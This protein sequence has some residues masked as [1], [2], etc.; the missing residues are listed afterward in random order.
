MTIRGHVDSM[1]GSYVTGWAT[2]HPATTPC[3]ITITDTLGNVLAKGHATTQRH[4]LASLDFGRADFAFRIPI[5]LTPENRLLRIWADGV[6]LPGSPIMAGA[7]QFDASFIFENGALGGWVTERAPVFSSPLIT[8]TDHHGQEAGRGHGVPALAPEDPLFNPAR[9]SI[10]LDDRCFGAG[11]MSMT[12][13]ING[14]KVGMFSCNLRLDGNL[15]SVT[16]ENCAGWLASPD[17]P[18][19]TFTIHVYRDGKLAGTA[20]CAHSREDVS[21]IYPDYETPGFGATLPPPETAATETTTLSLR[22]ANSQAELF[23]GPYTVGSRPAAILAAYRAASLANMN[24]P[25][26]GAAERAV[27]HLALSAFIAKSRAETSFTA[28]RQAESGIPRLPGPRLVIIIPVYRGVQVTRACIDSVLAHRN[29]QTDHLVLINDASP[30]HAMADMLAAYT[31]QPNIFLLTN[32]RNLGFVQTINRGLGF[33]AGADVLLLNSD[34]VVFSGA[35]DE[36]LRV[37]HAH[38]EIGTVTAM[39][40]NATIFSYPHATHRKKALADISWPD[41]A[42]CALAENAGLHVDVPTGHGFCMLIKGEVIRRI[43]LL[44]EAFGRGYG[45]ENDFCARAAAAGYRNVAAA[46][47]LVEHKESISF[48]NEKASLLARNLPRLN[49]LYPEYTPLIMAFEQTDGLR[50]TRWALDRIRLERAAAAGQSFV[51]VITNALEGGTPKAIADIEQ[52]IGYGAAHKLCLR[53]CDG[54][55]LELSCDSPLLLA[56]FTG[57]ETAALFTLL[58]AANPGR[59]LAHQLLGFPPSFISRLHAWSAG[60][61]SVFYAH[62]FYSF[63]PRVTMID[64]IGRFCD[65]ADTATCARCIEMEGAHEASRLTSLSPAAHRALFGELLG[66]MRHVVTPSANAASYLSR[67]FPDVTFEVLPHPENVAGVPDQPRPGTDDEIIL[68]GAIGPHKGSG[69]LLEIAQRARLTAPHLQFRIIG[70]TN[71]DK[72][73]KALG[74]VTITGKYTPDELP[75]LLAQSRGRFALFLSSWP[76]TYSY[77]LSEA[78]K[79]GFIPLLPDIGAPAA[80]VRAATLGAVFPFPVDAQAVL[81]LIAGIAAG[82][83]P[84]FAK[85]ASPRRFFPA[86]EVLQRTASLLG[87]PAQPPAPAPARPKPRRASTPKAA[88]RGS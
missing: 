5:P 36:L 79:Y 49:E 37:A 16:A 56:S 45:E 1:E 74:N 23:Q 17:A 34:T 58:T 15:E 19:R 70:Y 85:G 2:A 11:E 7:G 67:A 60:R 4:D 30:D 77:T 27:M 10:P 22:F 62:D 28:P 35:F 75:G 9:L 43:G 8:I 84:A 55:M 39:S 87:T 71:I 78:V 26:I 88:A 42:A 59:V 51:L 54:G 48:T 61:H 64:A 80:R 25:G 81:N 40:S 33:A 50:A 82:H 31:A 63:C 52:S 72:Q 18:A 68:L 12:I 6:E 47:V 46:G 76:E 32:A 3:A 41:L 66:G 73:L 86:A 21:A 69:K 13:A 24:L 20:P 38:A 57:D 44:D 53:A 14:T 65:I 29:A 83:I